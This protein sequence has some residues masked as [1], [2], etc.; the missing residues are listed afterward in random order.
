MDFEGITIK[1]IIVFITAM[2]LIAGFCYKIFSFFHQVKMNSTDIK[3]MKKK[4]KSIE[5]TRDIEKNELLNKVDETNSAVNLICSAVSAL[6][7]DSL[8]DNQESKNRLIEIKRKLDNKKE[9]V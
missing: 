3:E 9:I 5:Y 8:Q 2:G 4:I 7:E 6:I 1:E